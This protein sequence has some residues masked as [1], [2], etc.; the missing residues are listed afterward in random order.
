MVRKE[1]TLKAKLKK[2]LNAYY[3]QG[4]FWVEIKNNPS[5]KIISIKTDLLKISSKIKR[6]IVCLENK[7]KKE[8]LDEIEF[9]KLICLKKA[10][11]K[12]TM[13]KQEIKRILLQNG[14]CFYENIAG[15]IVDG[16]DVEFNLKNNNQKRYLSLLL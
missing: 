10:L 3:P 15:L 7:L 11:K 2:I 16:F 13:L 4:S 6:E 12:D 1:I 8:G 5:G 14:V 9:E